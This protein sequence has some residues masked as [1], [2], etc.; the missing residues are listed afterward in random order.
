[1]GLIQGVCYPVDFGIS[2][3]KDTMLD[4]ICV[5]IQE[6]AYSEGALHKALIFACVATCFCWVTVATSE[7]SNW[8]MLGET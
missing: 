7:H 4:Y 1:M 2:E 8:R 3:R 5:G 6:K